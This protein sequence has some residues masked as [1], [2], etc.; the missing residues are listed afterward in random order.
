MRI[1]TP[2]SLRVESDIEVLQAK[3]ALA[4]R[5]LIT[6]SKEKPNHFSVHRL[7]QDVTRHY[8]DHPVPILDDE[9]RPVPTDKRIFMSY[10]RADT[11]T[12]CAL[13]YR[14]L[15]LEFGAARIFRDVVSVE[16]GDQFKEEIDKAIDASG[17]VLAL[18]GPDWDTER[19]ADEND[20]VRYEL[21]AALTRNVPIIPILLR[22]ATMP[23]S[24]DLPASL[25]DLPG[26]N[27][28]QIEVRSWEGDLP[29]IVKG[30]KAKLLA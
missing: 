5:S 24:A 7:V 25:Q 10:R 16:L 13:L 27:A 17:V 21:Q 22:G 14:D 18:I 20:W 30:I 1:F 29:P 26:F 3:N 6:V 19:L 4:E 2:D 8:L 23:S 12:D 28:G 11:E 15:D 9:G